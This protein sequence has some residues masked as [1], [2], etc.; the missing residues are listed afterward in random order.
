MKNKTKR[1]ISAVLAASLL[2]LIACSTAPPPAAEEPVPEPPPPEP[3]VTA[4]Y[5]TADYEHYP[6]EIAGEAEVTEVNEEPEAVSLEEFIAYR[7][8]RYNHDISGLSL[9]V[10]TRDDIIFELTYG[11]LNPPAGP[12]VGPD[13]VFQWGSITKLLVYISVL[14]LY[15]RGELDLHADILTYLP[16]NFLPNITYPVTM[17]HLIHHSSGLMQRGHE[18]RV[19]FIP[20]GE[21]VPAFEDFIK[22]IFAGE[23]LIQFTPPGEMIFYSNEGSAFAGYLVERISGMPFYEYVFNNIFTPLGMSNTALLPDLSDND[24]VSLQREAAGI[25]R[26]QVVAYPSGSAAGTISDMVRFARALMPD[27]NGTSVLFENSE[28]MLKLSP[29]VEDI[30]NAP[31]DMFGNVY[32][33]G[34]LGL[35]GY[36]SEDRV[37]GHFGGTAD[38]ISALFVNID[39]GIGIVFSENITWTSGLQGTDKFF[40]GLFDKAFG[41]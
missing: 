27:E 3:Q 16:Q 29:S 15:E 2:F 30:L 24:W 38:F 14:Q 17:H 19:D 31:R 10:F 8:Q 26:L 35:F 20:F 28:T 25:P 11:Y 23:F 33:Y 18:F 9:S 21:P 32:F 36:E 37:L 39:R 13:T 34:F 4:D 40:E 5:I 41:G 6:D 1:L 7:I 12:P 22:D